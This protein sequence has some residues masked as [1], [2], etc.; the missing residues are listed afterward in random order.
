MN[1]EH[2]HLLRTAGRGSRFDQPLRV[3]ISALLGVSLGGGV[4]GWSSFGLGFAPYFIVIA[5][6]ASLPV[7]LAALVTFAVFLPSIRR[8]PAV[9]SAAA[10][11]IAVA[12]WAGCEYV[13]SPDGYGLTSVI[14][15][16]AVLDRTAL[17]FFCATIA[18][19]IFYGWER[20]LGRTKV[21]LQP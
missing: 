9:W 1:R 2:A 12:M 20:A 5:L 7:V 17:A 18:S 13:L 4:A 15:S 14:K 8:R 3:L 16:R 11:F 10:P 19:A 21:N 6:I